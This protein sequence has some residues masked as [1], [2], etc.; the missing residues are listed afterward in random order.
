MKT[1]RFLGSRWIASNHRRPPSRNDRF[2]SVIFT[3]L[4]LWHQ[5]KQIASCSFL[6]F[7]F[8]LVWVFTGFRP[9]GRTTGLT[10]VVVVAV[11]VVVVL[12]RAN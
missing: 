11:V 10:S 1:I 2:Y 4:L 9:F 3:G 8:F 12:R 7:V 5:L 6:L